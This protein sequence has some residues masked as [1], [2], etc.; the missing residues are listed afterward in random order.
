MVDD[1]EQGHDVKT[2]K[3]QSEML[4]VRGTHGTGHIGRVQRWTILT[5][6]QETRSFSSRRSLYET[7]SR[8][9]AYRRCCRVSIH[10]LKPSHHHSDLM[11]TTRRMARWLMILKG[12]VN[13]SPLENLLNK[14]W[15]NCTSQPV[16]CYLVLPGFATPLCHGL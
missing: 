12:A 11:R 5:Q 7:P 2:V 14:C 15:M 6:L 9:Q 16:K 13:I 4:F 3:K 10:T 8:S 1:E